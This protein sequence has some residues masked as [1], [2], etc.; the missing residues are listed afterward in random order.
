[1]RAT[2]PFLFRDEG[3]WFSHLIIKLLVYM[4]EIVHVAYAFRNE[5]L[6]R[7]EECKT[8][9]NPNFLKKQKTVISI[10]NPEFF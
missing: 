1:M 5:I 3:M 2:Y 8:L 7:E 9:E 6:L 4:Q 10:K